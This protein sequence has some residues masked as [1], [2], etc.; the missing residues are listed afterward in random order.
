MS[1]NGDDDWILMKAL[2]G[3]K[4]RNKLPNLILQFEIG[5]A[6]VNFLCGEFPM[7]ER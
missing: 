5:G 2:N 6:P 4:L 7:G 1:K 3:F